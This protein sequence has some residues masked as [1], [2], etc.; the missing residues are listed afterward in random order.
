MAMRQKNNTALHS[1][2]IAAVIAIVDQIAKG[3]IEQWIGPDHAHHSWWLINESIGFSY[4]ENHGVAFGLLRGQ[5][6]LAL[7]AGA[8]VTSAAIIWFTRAFSGNLFVSIGGGLVIG[9]AI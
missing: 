1:W 5:S 2:L 7:V 9:G 6:T 3:A 8:A 4:A